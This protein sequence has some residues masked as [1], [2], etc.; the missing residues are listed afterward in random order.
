MFG[1]KYHNLNVIEISSTKLLQNYHDLTKKYGVPVAPVLKSNA[2]GHDITLVGKILDAV[3][4][5]FFCVDSLFEA[6]KLQK[7]GIKTPVLVMGYIHPE[8]LEVKKLPFSFAVFTAEMLNAV[9]KYQPQA[10]VHIFVDTG[11]HREGVLLKDLAAFVKKA[12]G[13]NI[14]GLMTHLATYKNKG[15]LE[16]FKKAQEI[17]A[18]K[19]IHPGNVWRLGLEL[20]KDVLSFKAT[21]VQIKTLVKG[22]KVGYDFTFT[23]KKKMKIGIVAAG[24]NDGVDRKLSNISPFVGRISMNI[25]AVD[26]AKFPGAKAGDQIILPIKN[27]LLFSYETLVHLNPM[28]KRVVT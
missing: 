18:P 23:A 6:Y 10:P 9:R 15:Q 17:I 14:E 13:L 5:P 7:A 26:M 12:Q 22:D 11:M 21:I 1:R 3:R 16:N 27:K 19:W 24:Y 4:A 28:T 8:S 25:S 20:Y 2:Y